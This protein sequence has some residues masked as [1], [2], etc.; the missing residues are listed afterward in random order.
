MALSDLHSA[1]LENIIRD[2]LRGSKSSHTCHCPDC[3]KELDMDEREAAGLVT[4]ED[5]FIP[6]V[7]KAILTALKKLESQLEKAS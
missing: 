1:Q 6:S 5:L 7:A 4:Y 3:K 2:A